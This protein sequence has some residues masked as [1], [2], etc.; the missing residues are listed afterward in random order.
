MTVLFT[1]YLGFMVAQLV[2]NPSAMWEMVQFLGWK[3]PLR[4]ERLPTPV[5]WPGEFHELYSPWG[6]KESDTTEQLSGSLEYSKESTILEVPRGDPLYL[7]EHGAVHGAEVAGRSRQ[8]A[9]HLG[10]QRALLAAALGT[11][12]RC[13]PG[14]AHRPCSAVGTEI[15][16]KTRMDNNRKWC[17]NSGNQQFCT[18]SFGR[19]CLL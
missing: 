10:T 1:G 14:A 12:G 9:R 8:L 5:F 19:C 16:R 3:N 7:C 18:G 4:R 13:R 6:C 2:K 15:H 11:A 17:W